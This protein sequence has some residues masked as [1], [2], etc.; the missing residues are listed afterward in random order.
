MLRRGVIN[1]PESN[2]IIH[3]VHI[4]ENDALPIHLTFCIRLELCEDAKAKLAW[5]KHDPRCMK[6]GN[7]PHDLPNGMDRFG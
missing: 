4:T 7:V 3:F 2:A 5:T 1:N 6:L